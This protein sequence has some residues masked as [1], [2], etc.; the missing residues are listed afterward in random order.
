MTKPALGRC[1]AVFLTQTPAMA[2]CFTHLED[3]R[4]MKAILNVVAISAVIALCGCNHNKTSANMGAVDD[5]K[6]NCCTSGK[7]SGCCSDKSKS[8]SETSTNGTN[9]G[10]VSD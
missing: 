9:M 4:S 1:F 7:S 3:S 10:A 8:T 5:T 6:S 2:G